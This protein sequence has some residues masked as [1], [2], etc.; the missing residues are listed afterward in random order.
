MKNCVICGVLLDNNNKSEEHIIHNAIGG[1]LKSAQIYCKE[2][3]Q[4]YGSAQDIEFT[5]IFAPIVDRID[6]HKDR[7]TNGTSYTGTMYDEDYNLYTATYKMGKVVELFDDELKYVKYEEGKYTTLYYDFKLDNDMLKLGLAKIAFNYAIHC[8]LDVNNLERVFDNSQKALVPQ[9]L[10]IPFIPL[11]LFDEVMEK[12]A[13][14][15]FHA[16]RIF[17]DGRILYAY[18]ELFST[19]QFYIVLSEKYNFEEVGEMDEFYGNVVERYEQVDKKLIDK[20]TPRDYKQADI[21]CTQY[22]LDR[23]LLVED[24]KRYHQYDSFDDLKK[25]ELIFQQIGKKAYEKN[26]KESYIKRYDELINSHYSTIDFGSI[27]F[28]YNSL[29]QKMEFYNQFNFYTIYDED[30]VNIKIYKKVL[31]NGC[32]YPIAIC[33]MMKEKKLI[34]QYGY[35][36]L[37]MLND[38]ILNLPQNTEHAK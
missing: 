15:L 6:I 21:I 28:S 2:C 11:T 35:Q 29:E 18:I 19:F 7:K 38:Y 24:L 31:P 8:G 25:V 20:L 22:E 13:K 30:C 1:S 26:R 5:R 27:L 14:K 12:T 17:N 9:P 10:V 4:K 36:K 34:A 3:N 37:N 33:N 32:S 16:V 23:N